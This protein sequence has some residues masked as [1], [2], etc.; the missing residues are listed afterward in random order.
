[1]MM[2]MIPLN[3][4]IRMKEFFLSNEIETL[5]GLNVGKKKRKKENKTKHYNNAS[6][7]I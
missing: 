1:M 3:N 4:S 2:M 5:S 7:K 6:K